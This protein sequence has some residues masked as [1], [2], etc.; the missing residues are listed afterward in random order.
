MGE[1]DQEWGFNR[2]WKETEDSW[3]VVATFKIMYITFRQ[4]NVKSIWKGVFSPPEYKN[5]IDVFIHEL[6]VG[7]TQSL[8][9][10]IS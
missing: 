3:H 1:N 7:N 2:N 9:S 5:I 10:Y 6:L 8:L 4:P